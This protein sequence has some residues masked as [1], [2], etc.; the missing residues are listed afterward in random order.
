MRDGVRDTA[1]EEIG[2]E[3]FGAQD[4]VAPE[5]AMTSCEAHRTRRSRASVLAKLLRTDDSLRGSVVP[6]GAVQLAVSVAGAWRRS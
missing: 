5:G 3:A 6:S 4:Q 2:V 1:Q